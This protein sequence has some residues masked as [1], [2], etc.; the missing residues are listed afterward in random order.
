MFIMIAAAALLRQQRAVAGP[1][2]DILTDINST[3]AKQRFPIFTHE[4]AQQQCT[5]AHT[6]QFIQYNTTTRLF[7]TK[8]GVVLRQQP[9]ELLLTH[10]TVMNV[11]VYASTPFLPGSPALLV[12][13]VTMH[14]HL[15]NGQYH[16]APYCQIQAALQ[17]GSRG[18]AVAAFDGMQPAVAHQ[19]STSVIPQP[20][21]RHYSCCS[22]GWEQLTV[23]VHETQ[24]SPSVYMQT[25]V[26]I[27]SIS[28]TLLVAPEAGNS[29]AVT[30]SRPQASPSFHMQM[31][32][33]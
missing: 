17:H 12:H 14:R 22:Q 15:R 7:R 8:A 11:F 32:R 13:Q 27:I 6:Q 1:G 2:R 26:C 16:N 21:I 4:H 25:C 28:A 31:A 30:A 18:V 29:S 20:L 24:A 9:R 5:H 19:Y 3:W 23:T 33:V 10:K